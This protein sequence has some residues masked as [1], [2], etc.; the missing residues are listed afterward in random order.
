M[1]HH[2]P[3]FLKYLDSGAM[4]LQIYCIGVG[5]QRIPRGAH[6]PYRPE[7]HPPLYPY[8]TSKGRVLDE[9][10]LVYVVDGGGRFECS[11]VSPVH[12]HPGTAFLLF[13]ALWHNYCADSETGWKHYWVGF[14]GSFMDT[15]VQQRFFTPEAPIFEIGLHD[16]LVSDYQ[17][18]FETLRDE[19]PG[20]Q[21]ITAGTIIK[22]LGSVHSL[23][24]Q[25]QCTDG[26][27]RP[28][29]EGQVPVRRARQRP[30]RDARRQRRSAHRLLGVQ[31]SLQAQHRCLSV[32]LLPG[33]ESREGKGAARGRPSAGQG[34][35][36]TAVVPRTRTTSRACSSA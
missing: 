8:D 16:S 12:I 21:L 7:L 13:P 33:D 3:E 29:G 1:T 14:N 15:L 27:E 6:Q 2:A 19:P 4:E 17:D 34:G 20:F 24:R 10:Q 25:D 22:M 35:G 9:Y 30:P 11:G 28:G 5:N 18:I 26:T 32:P 31:P 23:A 36:A